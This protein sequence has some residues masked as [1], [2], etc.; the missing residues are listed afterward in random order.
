MVTGA[1][2]GLG[3]VIA[4]TLAEEGYDLV[5][6]DV[7]ELGGTAAEV[8][9][10]GGQAWPRVMDVS[11]ETDV[12]ALAERLLGEG[13]CRGQGAHQAEMAGLQ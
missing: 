9:E 6:V 13:L 2:R 3:R 7:A 1:A 10:R 11:S 12:V 8:E 5:L 4:K